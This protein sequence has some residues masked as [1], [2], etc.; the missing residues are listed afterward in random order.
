MV[1]VPPVDNPL[2]GHLIDG[3]DKAAAAGRHG[4]AQR[5]LAEAKAAAPE[6][7]R[8]LSALGL[9]ALKSGDF[10]AARRY[11]D[12]AVAADPRSASLWFHLAL[13]CRAQGDAGA[14]LMALDKSLA[15]DAESYLALLQKASLL[16]R[17]GKPKQ[18]AQVYVYFLHCVPPPAQRPPALQKAVQQAQEAVAADK[19]ALGEFIRERIAHARTQHA[20]ARQDRFEHCLEVLLGRR[21]VFTPQPTFMHFPHL[22]AIEFY[23]RED[24]PWLDEFEAAT[25]AIRDELLQVLAQGSEAQEIVPYVDYPDG[26][27]PEQWRELNRSLQWGAYYLIKDGVRLNSHLACCPKTAALLDAAPLADVPDQAPTAF[28][29]LLKP[30]TRIPPHTGVTNTRLVVHVPLV[31]PPGCGFRVGAETREWQPGR[32]WVFDDTIEHEAWNESDAPRA[33]LIIDIWN[34]FL[35]EAERALVRAATVAAADFKRE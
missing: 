16:E 7:P 4:E 22:P 31:I 13:A 35:T 21:R 34:P 19:A 2:I 26:V 25:D 20:G 14:E 11:L 6:H 9:Y 5:L 8:V 28:F 30:R 24:F 32:A 33:I 29:S 1:A 3:A 18:A 15:L 27:P 23:D 12:E 17:Q 10:P